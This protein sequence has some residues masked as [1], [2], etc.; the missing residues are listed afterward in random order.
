MEKPKTAARM[1]DALWY[2]VFGMNEKDG[3]L[4]MVRQMWEER[5][6]APEL[7]TRAD[8]FKER[9]ENN[10]AAKK[11]RE[12]NKERRKV[13]REAI[14]MLIFTGAMA[15]G[16]IVTVAIMLARMMGKH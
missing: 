9:D 1:L 10:S 12:K 4:A 5:Q 2:A 11:E 13:S 3:M 16:T 14:W 6:G 15:L 7:W 8:H